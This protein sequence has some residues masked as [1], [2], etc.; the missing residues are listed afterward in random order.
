MCRIEIS[1]QLV[2]TMKKLYKKNR[3]R[4]ETFKKKIVE[5]DKSENPYKNLG[6][7]MKE[8]KRVHIDSHFVLIFKIEEV[9]IRLETLRHH[10]E[11]Y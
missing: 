2:K 3:A 6:H 9:V 1:T 7:N 8:Y 4:Y 11:I 5:I 10:D